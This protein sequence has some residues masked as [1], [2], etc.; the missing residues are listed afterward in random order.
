MARD[1]KFRSL[2]PKTQEEI[3]GTNIKTL[4]DT[5]DEVSVEDMR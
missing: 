3:A 5:Y 4:R 2:P 1:P